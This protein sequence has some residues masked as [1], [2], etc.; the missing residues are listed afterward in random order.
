[1]LRGPGPRQPLPPTRAN[2]TI[3][4]V[5][6]VYQALRLAM[7]EATASQPGLDPLQ[8]SFTVALNTA[9]DQV[10]R[11]AGVIAAAAI[12]LI[13]M[14]GRAVLADLLPPRRT[15]R[16]PRVVKPAISKHRAKGD[17]DR[18]NHQTTISVKILHDNDLTPS[19]EP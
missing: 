11:A 1:M 17:I 3:S 12:D 6:T 4:A 19:A 10:I 8:A 14:I 5:L 13:G 2:P 7:S 16:S 9:R 15:R 18:G